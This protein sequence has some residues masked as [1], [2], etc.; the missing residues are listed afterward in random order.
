MVRCRSSIDHQL[1][2]TRRSGETFDAALHTAPVGNGSGSAEAQD[3]VLLADT[4]AR[5]ELD[6]RLAHASKM[7]SI[8]RLAGG[9]A[10][11][12]NNL[13]LVMRSHASLLRERL[14][15]IV[16]TE[17]D[18]VERAA[19][20]AGRLVRQLLAFSR[21]A[22]SSRPSSTPTWSS[23]ASNRCSDR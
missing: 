15:E 6:Q 11:D 21:T 19:D 13:L 2:C 10:H 16:A 17:L 5:K 18:E 1:T 4:T 9:I 23:R 7:E 12:F 14:G 8:G 20:D 22:T 3:I